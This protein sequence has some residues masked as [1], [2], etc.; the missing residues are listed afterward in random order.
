[1]RHA[2]LWILGIGC[3]LASCGEDPPPPVAGGSGNV[4]AGRGGS[5]IGAGGSETEG[6]EA[7]GGKPTSMGGAPEVEAGTTSLGGND[8]V[9]GGAPPAACNQGKGA[10]I[11][12]RILAPNGELDMLTAQGL[13]HRVEAVLA[14]H[15]SVV[16]DLS[17]LTFVDSAGMRVLLL[18]HGTG[19][20]ELRDASPAVLQT[21]EVAKVAGM[22]L[23]DS[24][25]WG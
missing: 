14:E 16:I 9:L 3:G 19:R 2:L 23:G 8:D 25:R 7:Q 21:F 24:S 15:A 11:S 10:T 6:G 1:M 5:L 13:Q 22:L 17:G 4:G 20:V 18:A 12:G